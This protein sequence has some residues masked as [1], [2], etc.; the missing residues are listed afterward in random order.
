MNQTLKQAFD[1]A[2][3]LSLEAQNIIAQ[4]IFNEIKN[5]QTNQEQQLNI[6]NQE[7]TNLSQK[8]WEQ[9][10]EEVEKIEPISRDED[11]INYQKII[12][13]KYKKQGLEL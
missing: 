1:Q 2:S 10:F 8:Y 13:D 6:S 9:W 11:E 12:F 5:N 7:N 4:I 3:Q